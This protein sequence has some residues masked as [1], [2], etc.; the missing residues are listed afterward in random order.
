MSRLTDVIKNLIIINVIVYIAI[1]TIPE[2]FKVYT[3]LGPM[4]FFL[5]DNFKPFQ[6]VTSMFMHANVIHLLMNM[7]GLYFLGPTVE[8]VLGS[9]RFLILY[10]L[11]GLG[12][13]LLHQ[14]TQYIEY[15]GLTC[16]NCIEMQYIMGIPVLGASGAIYGVVIAFMTMFPNEKLMIIPIPIPIKA[17]YL[18]MAMVAAALYFGISDNEPGGYAHFA[19]LGGALAGFILIHFWKMAK[20]R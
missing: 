13:S 2:T 9:K 5:S 10:I 4:F 15:S 11:A 12:G 3:D 17:A 1:K 19:H 16:T 14:I 6:I 7:M 20:L 8:R 18:G